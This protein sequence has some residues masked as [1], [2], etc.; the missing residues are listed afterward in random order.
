MTINLL[1]KV[2]NNWL[3]KNKFSEGCA[4]DLYYQ[5]LD[6]LDKNIPQRK[7]LKRFIN[8]WEK[9]EHKPNGLGI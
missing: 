4:E 7:W 8:L 6:N 2:Y 5:L 1:T 3:S 9:V